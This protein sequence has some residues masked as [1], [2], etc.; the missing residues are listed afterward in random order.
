MYNPDIRNQEAQNMQFSDNKVLLNPAESIDVVKLINENQILKANNQY[1]TALN[2][3]YQIEISRL[4]L[5]LE[6]F[7][8][9]KALCQE[10]RWVNVCDL[11]NHGYDLKSSL[12]T[13]SGMFLCYLRLVYKLKVAFACDSFDN[14]IV[15]RLV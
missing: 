8:L 2:N 11:Y 5:Q 3:T 1:L 10:E 9:K 4:N 15:A 6:M 14:F 13:N 7:E 12:M